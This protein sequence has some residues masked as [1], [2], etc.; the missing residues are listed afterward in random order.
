MNAEAPPQRRIDRSAP[1][2]RESDRRS[3]E[4][5][6]VRV[7]GVGTVVW[8]LEENDSPSPELAVGDV[9]EVTVNGVIALRGTMHE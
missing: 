4:H 6:A 3:V 8:R 9:V 7:G 1:P 5:R 2:P